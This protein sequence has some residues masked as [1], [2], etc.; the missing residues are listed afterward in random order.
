MIDAQP[1]RSADRID[2]LVAAAVPVELDALAPRD[3][4]S[5][6]RLR[7]GISLPVDMDAVVKISSQGS[8]T[9]SLNREI[10]CPDAEIVG[11][12]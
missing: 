9:H 10:P 7:G 8:G 11:R 12:A 5:G 2:L 1:K 4:G 3:S 6:V